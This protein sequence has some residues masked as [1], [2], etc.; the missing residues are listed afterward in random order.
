MN[1]AKEEIAKAIEAH[2]NWKIRLSEAVESGE[3][4]TP[5]EVIEKDNECEFGKWLFNSANIDYLKSTE[6]F[7]EIV[8]LHAEFHKL[9]AE[10]SKFAINGKKSN[11]K[12][13]MT[14]NGEYTAISKKLIN[15]L[16]NWRA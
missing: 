2:E 3:I 12:K 4:D 5:I 15:T 7:N 16:N 9:A 8:L 11:A 1:N 13:L 6:T 14:E 10:I